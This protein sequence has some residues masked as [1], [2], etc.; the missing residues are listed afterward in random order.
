M[1]ENTSF[2]KRFDYCLFQFNFTLHNV[3]LIVIYKERE[4]F[5]DKHLKLRIAL[6]FDFYKSITGLLFDNDI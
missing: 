3:D 6:H 4:R 5:N 1:T 2:K